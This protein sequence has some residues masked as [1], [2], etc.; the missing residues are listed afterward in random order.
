MADEIV[1]KVWLLHG[2]FG[3]GT[4]GILALNNG[5]V[6]FVSEEGEHFNVHLAD[7]KEVKWPFISFGYAMNAVINGEKYKFSFIKPNGAADLNDSTLRQ[8]VSLTPAGRGIDA[9]ATL[10][11]L[12][13][14]KKAA[15]EWKA[16]LA[17]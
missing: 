2:T 17:S 3:G 9:I 16:V 11:K 8:L 7:V 10:S 13:K 6:S 4:P 5:N 12:G 15:K 1:C 14:D